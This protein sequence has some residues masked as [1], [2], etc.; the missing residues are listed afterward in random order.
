[1]RSKGKV[2]SWNEDK[3][4]GFIIPHGGGD[5]LFIHKNCLVNKKRTP[6]LQDVITYTNSKDKQGRYCAIDATFTGEKLKK[7]Q[8]NSISKLSLYLAFLFLIIMVILVTQDKAPITLFYLYVGM[9]FITFI[10][11]LNDKNKAQKGSWRTSERRLHFIAL[12]GGWPGAAIAQQLLR[13]KSQKLSFRFRFWLTV[14][15]NITV[16][17]WLLLPNNE[18]LRSIFL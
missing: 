2:I 11:Y 14:I 1:L 7:K 8:A 9:S 17:F 16:I 15:I 5:K 18:D 6:Q 4:F 13:H 3:A 10:I 12:I